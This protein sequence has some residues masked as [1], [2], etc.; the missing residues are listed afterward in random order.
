MPELPLGALHTVKKVSRR[1]PTRLSR[2]L[3]RRSNRRP[4]SFPAGWD[5]ATFAH[6]NYRQDRRILEGLTPKL[7]VFGQLE[8]RIGMGHGVRPRWFK[9]LEWPHGQFD[10]STTPPKRQRL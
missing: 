7:V 6:Y 3:D 9:G 10:L 5:P 2:V 8:I 4:I 1:S